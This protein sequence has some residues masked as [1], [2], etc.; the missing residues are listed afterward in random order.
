MHGMHVWQ[1]TEPRKSRRRVH[2]TRCDVLQITGQPGK[3]GKNGK[4]TESPL[5]KENDLS[6]GR[7]GSRGRIPPVATLLE[8]VAWVVWA[9]LNN[10]RRGCNNL[11]AG[12]L[13][14]EMESLPEA[15][16]RI[17]VCIQLNEYQ[18]LCIAD[19]F[20]HAFWQ[21]RQFLLSCNEKPRLDSRQPS[22]FFLP[23]ASAN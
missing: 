22:A 20:G 15:A 7:A 8:F 19:Q 1:K 23:D 3:K 16:L 12:P 21:N 18:C 14:Q 5:G 4:G 13:L 17:Q 10:G 2:T 11:H 6:E 9:E